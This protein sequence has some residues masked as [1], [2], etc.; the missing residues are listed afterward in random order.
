MRIALFGGTFDPVHLGHL[1]IAEQARVELGLQRVF[2][3]LTPNPPHKSGAA[4][5]PVVHRLEMLKTAVSGHP[6]FAIS[7]IELERQGP[8]FTVDTLRSFRAMPEFVQ[9]EF[10]LIIGADSFLELNKWREPQTIVTMT[11]L[12]IYPRSGV[13][14]QRAAPEFLRVAHLLRGP[15]I[16]IS[17]TEI[18]QRCNRGVSIRYLVPEEV[19]AYIIKSQLYQQANLSGV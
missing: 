8:S 4:I 13:N 10:Y 6:E 7:T 1:I 2:F 9:A 19:R 5:S 18:R 15:L 17:S 11:K 16:E 12:A 3:V 14:V